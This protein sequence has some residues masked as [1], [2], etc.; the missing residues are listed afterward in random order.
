ME[1][2]LLIWVGMGLVAALIGRSKGGSGIGW[3]LLGVLFGPIAWLF[4]ALKSTDKKQESSVSNELRKCPYCAE[5]IKSEA[6]LCKHCGK[7]L[8]AV[9]AQKFSPN[10][11]VP[12]EDLSL[13]ITDLL[14][15]Y[16][17][18]FKGNQYHWRGTRYDSYK[19]P[20]AHAQTEASE[21]AKA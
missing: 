3:F 19:E 9:T 17:I 10:H 1:V 14:R 6:I 15:K 4:A 2:I 16:E 13:N 5:L 12:E 8:P 7:D 11:L 21:S 18:Y 20:L